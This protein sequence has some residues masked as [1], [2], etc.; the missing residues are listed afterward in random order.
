MRITCII[1][2]QLSGYKIE[3]KLHFS[4]RERIRLNNTVVG[5][6]LTDGGEDFRLTRRQ[7]FTTPQENS[8]YKYSLLTEVKRT[9]LRTDPSSVPHTQPSFYRGFGYTLAFIVFPTTIL[10]Y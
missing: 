9:N 8:C 4:V 5:N 7:R 2:K 10:L 3:E 1:N 6:R